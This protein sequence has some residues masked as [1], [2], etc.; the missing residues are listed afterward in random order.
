MS[1]NKNTW[2]KVYEYY[3][4]FNQDIDKTYTKCKIGKIR[5]QDM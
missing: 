5:I 4:S 2:M 3:F 1:E